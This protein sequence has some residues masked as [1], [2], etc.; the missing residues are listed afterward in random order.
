MYPFNLGRKSF[1]TFAFAIFTLIAFASEA[2]R[3]EIPADGDVLVKY[4]S[5]VKSKF[6][7]E[8]ILPRENIKVLVWNMYKAGKESWD[9][10]FPKITKG[11]DILMLQ[12]FFSI[13]RMMEVIFEDTDR[14]YVLSTSFK[15]TKEHARTGVATASSFDFRRVGWQRSYYREPI[16]RTPKMTGIATFDLAGTDKDLLTLN[17][18]AINFVS[19][20]KLAH[21]VNEGLKYAG[22]HDGPVIFAG[23]FNTW[24]KGKQRMLFKMMKENGFSN[25][26]FNK[27][28]RMRT[29]GNI[30]DWVFVRDLKVT[31]S[32]VY[33]EVEG[34]D[35]KA[36][37]VHVSY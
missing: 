2:G 6:R 1:K 3:Y 27:D 17:I 12:E 8:P 33:G 25:V 26:R 30:L 15:D 7:N 10:D 31:Y 22:A 20:R 18:H 36:M 21:M 32:K 4:N 34:S 37:E 13:P 29:F 28:T 14:T 23:D 5:S 35:H 9:V 24:S 16:I 11:K 19:T